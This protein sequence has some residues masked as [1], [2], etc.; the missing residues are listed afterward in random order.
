[1]P[2]F[3]R[4]VVCAAILILGSGRAIAQDRGGFTVLVDLGVG[5][6]NDSAIAESAIGLA[7]LGFGAGA[8]LN[9][10]L[11]A[12]FRLSGTHVSYDL[13][14]FDYGQTSG[15]AGPAMQYWLSDQLNVEA[16]AGLGFWR[17]D[18]DDN[19]RGFGLLLGAGFSILN[20]GKHNVQVGAQYMPAFTAPGTVHSFGITLGYQFQ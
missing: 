9:E 4:I 19:S 20:R 17:G 15:F 2:V 12:M 10:N 7:G 18:N 8:F 14:G 3:I 5:A 16:G 6:Q 13:N 11:A 1:M